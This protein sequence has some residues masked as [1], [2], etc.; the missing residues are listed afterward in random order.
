MS[1]FY[2]IRNEGSLVWVS[3]YFKSAGN[4]AAIN[5]MSNG[6]FLG[7]YSYPI[8]EATQL[9]QLILYD[10]GQL[11]N[12]R[13]LNLGM[14]LSTG[15]IHQSVSAQNT[16][17]IATNVDP[18][19]SVTPDIKDFLLQYNEDEQEGDCLNWNSFDEV[20]PNSLDVKLKNYSFE[21]QAFE[22]TEEQ[23]L[24][25]TMINFS[26]PLYEFCDET[27]P[28]EERYEERSLN[29]NEDWEISLP[30][31]DFHWDDINNNAPRVLTDP[32]IYRA[33][34]IKCVDPI[35]IEFKLEKPD[36]ECNIY[37][38]N[39]LIASGI[40]GNQHLSIDSDCSVSE[41]NLNV[42]DRWGQL[43]FN[44]TN[45]YASWTPF[46]DQE[47]ISSGVFV[48]VLEYQLIGINGN[49]QKGIIVQDLTLIK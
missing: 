18:F 24:R 35:I 6:T 34:K 28:A 44:S 31:E 39:V 23:N 29:C 2:K 21:T 15:D 26:F 8:E 11:G 20:I 3:D 33:R 17:T 38:P 7:T 36:C 45:A 49:L 37:I 10:N 46:E 32:G 40:N 42:Y 5:T 48:C 19:S 47:L 43:V 16:V 9:S 30:S 4:S 22:M 41:M 12:L 25:A 13:K 14:S 27:I 1:F